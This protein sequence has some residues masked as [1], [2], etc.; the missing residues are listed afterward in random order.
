MCIRVWGRCEWVPY[1]ICGRAG[2]DFKKLDAVGGT[3]MEVVDGVGVTCRGVVTGMEF[4]AGVMGGNC[5]EFVGG[6]CVAT[7]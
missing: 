3:C 5:M 4:V 1:R 7:V 6:T 2:R